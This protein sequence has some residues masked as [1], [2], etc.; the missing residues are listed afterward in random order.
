MIDIGLNGPEDLAELQRVF[1]IVTVVED[2]HNRL[3][4]NS[5]VLEDVDS[6]IGQLVKNLPDPPVDIRYT[7]IASLQ[8][9]RG[10]LAQI[11]TLIKDGV[12]TSPVVLQT[13][14]RTS[15]LSGGRVVY[16]LGPEDAD[17]R[18]AHAR[19]VLRQDSNS[20]MKAY[21]AFEKFEHSPSLKPGSE[22]LEPQRERN[23]ILQSWG[24]PIG[25]EKALAA[26]A[27]VV[28]EEMLRRGFQV[29]PG[30]FGE[31]ITWLFHVGSGAA[32]GFGWPRLVPGTSSMAGIFLPDF[33]LVASVAHLAITV[34]GG[35]R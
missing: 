7:I 21:A 6:A 34:V 24:A 2:L 20:L 11:A 5:A 27:S 25:E 23:R 19:V 9:S 3:F 13:L 33:S 22:V 31:H 8:A 26:M 30:H 10:C 18:L 32:H 29:D 14:L 4:S 28:E 17:T 12:P 15:L 1:E 35:G 16:M